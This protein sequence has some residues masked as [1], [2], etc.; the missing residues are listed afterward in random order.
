MPVCS[1]C[2]RHI[3]IA[4]TERECPSCGAS[5]LPAGDSARIS[6]P[7][8]I[9]WEYETTS[10]S[11]IWACERYLNDMGEDGWELVGIYR[12][13]GEMHAIFKRPKVF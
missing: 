5:F 2:G 11:S 4:S 3:S 1:N 12:G 13:D 7:K 10:I 9:R 6:T 8:V